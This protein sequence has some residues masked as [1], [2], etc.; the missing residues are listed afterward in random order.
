MTDVYADHLVIKATGPASAF[1]TVF[2]A[3]L[4]DYQK[5]DHRYHRPHHQPSVPTLLKDLLCVVE[6]LDQSASFRPHSVNANVALPFAH[7]QP[8]LPAGGTTATGVPGNYTVGDV[9][10]LYNVNPL[11]AQH[12]DGH[13]GPSASR[14]S[15][16]SCPTTRTRTG[17]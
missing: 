15:P 17:R 6:G 1:N 11:Y 12:I 16:A 8:V 2:S 14:R 4:H 9:A 5:P 3:D 13:G 10:N 7:N